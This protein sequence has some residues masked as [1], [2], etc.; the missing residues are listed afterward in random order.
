MNTK[1]LGIMFACAWFTGCATTSKPMPAPQ[2]TAELASW[3]FAKVL[4]VAKTGNVPAIH[5]ACFSYSYGR[6]GAPQ[7]EDQAFEWC[8][9]GHAGGALPSTTLLAELLYYGS[10]K[11]RDQKRARELYREAAEDG[12]LFAT[13]MVGHLMLEHGEDRDEARAWLE[14]AAKNGLPQAI[15]RLDE[16]NAEDR[17][18]KPAH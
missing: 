16:M 10:E 13:Y 12:H 14:L 1:R 15:K 2:S 17:I 11:H 9:R 3:P 5:Q 18:A 4:K 7:D 8:T 6:N